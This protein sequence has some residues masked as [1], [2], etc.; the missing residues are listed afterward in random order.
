M[1]LELYTNVQQKIPKLKETK[2]DKGIYSNILS[3]DNIYGIYTR[4]K[5]EYEHKSLD[6]YSDITINFYN[7]LGLYT[8]VDKIKSN[9]LDL[10]SN[11]ISFYF[12]LGIYSYIE[13][14]KELSTVSL[15]SNISAVKENNLDLFSY[16]KTSDFKFLVYDKEDN[17]ILSNINWELYRRDKSI[18]LNGDINNSHILVTNGFSV[19]A[20]IDI[21]LDDFNL[22]NLDNDYYLHVWKD[23]DIYHDLNLQISYYYEKYI[24]SKKNYYLKSNLYLKKEGGNV[25]EEKIIY[26]GIG[27]GGGS[28]QEIAVTSRYISKQDVEVLCNFNE[29]ITVKS[30]LIQT[31]ILSEC[32]NI[33]FEGVNYV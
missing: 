5:L 29:K 19:D 31:D 12:S 15:Y 2:K 26:K 23:E 28:P 32:I 11:I 14:T 13:E 6:L 24:N 30:K 21:F 1:I 10:Y 27:G 9:Q 7:E 18:S 22:R 25:V 4:Y 16:I 8:I 3:S 33:Q 17:L 20:N